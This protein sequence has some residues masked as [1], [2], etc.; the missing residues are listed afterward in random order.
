VITTLDGYN[1][2]GISIEGV[3]TVTNT[4]TS[5]QDLPSFTT[6]MTNGKIRWPDGTSIERDE[7]TK[8]EIKPG[9]SADQKQ[10][11]ISGS[12]TG[13][14]RRDVDYSV[15]IGEKLV[16][17]ASCAAANRVI[18]PVRGTKELVV[19]SKKISID[20]GDGSC[21]R[22]ATVTIRSRSEEVEVGDN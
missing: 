12:A 16:Y 18:M 21:D 5:T 17:K 15:T 13:K 1:I 14:T 2:N 20:Y 4:T 10:W 22:K 9:S 8:M 11:L 3:R 19:N 7:S 6:V